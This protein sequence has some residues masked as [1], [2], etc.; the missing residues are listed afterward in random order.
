M[1]KSKKTNTLIYL[2]LIIII[3]SGCIIMYLKDNKPKENNKFDKY[4]M[5]KVDASIEMHSLL[6]NYIKEFSKDDI[7]LSLTDTYF[8]YRK[9]ITKQVDLIIVPKPTENEINLMTENNVDIE[10]TK[11]VYDGIVFIVNK[12]NTIDNLTIE[13]VNNIYN[14]TI[15]N[16]YAL[17]GNNSNILSY[18]YN[19]DNI[20]NSFN[21]IVMN[22]GKTKVPNKYEIKEKQSN[23]IDS[24]TYNNSINSIG[25]SSYYYTDRIHTNEN[26]K[27]LSINNVK[28]SY[29]TISNGK[30]PFLIEYYIVTRKGETN[31]NVLKLKNLMI[32]NNGEEII[33]SSKYSFIKN[34]RET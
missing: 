7:E 15:K 2:F 6:K 9:L 4:T 20:K 31:K 22:G 30:Y 16:W 24:F 11:L 21:Q 25:Y 12:N 33:K 27:Y 26:I 18:Q 8:A 32:S 3:L 14:G 5:P 19:S 28:P 1:K 23:M 17:N 10:M 13:Q 29:E 34:S